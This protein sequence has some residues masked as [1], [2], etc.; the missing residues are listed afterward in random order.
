MQKKNAVIK[1]KGF[2]LIE[3]M[4]AFAII[5]I[6][7]AI[8]IPQYNKYAARAQVAD[9]FTSLGPVKKAL[10]L[11]YQENGQFP[12]HGHFNARAEAVGILR[13]NQWAS[14]TDYIWRLFITNTNGRIRVI[15]KG[16]SQGVNELIANRRFEFWPVLN[17]S[18]ITSWKCRPQ[19]NA[20]QRIGE[21]YIKFCL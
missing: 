12:Q 21:E 8:F 20:R 5:G 6:L 3:L 10:T 14:A 16:S 9:A 15:F 2:T 18:V 11:Y 17:G 7:A 1:Q 13:R 4:I 19:G